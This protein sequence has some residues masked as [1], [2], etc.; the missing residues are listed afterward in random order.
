M[1][2]PRTDY[3]ANNNVRIFRYAE[4]L[5]MNSEAKIRQGKDGDNGYNLVRARAEM[6]TK[7]GVTLDDVLDERRME[8][9]NEWCN[10]YV[11][12]VRTGKAAAELGPKGWTEAKTYWPLPSKAIFIPNPYHDKKNLNQLWNSLCRSDGKGNHG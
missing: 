9:C 7:S 2:L 4:V 6:P 3:G 10:R 5:L 8:L 1:T 12:L 11:D